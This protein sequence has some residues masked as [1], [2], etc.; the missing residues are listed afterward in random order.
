[1]YKLTKEN[2]TVI[3]I[4]DYALIPLPPNTPEGWNYMDWLA[5]GGIPEPYVE[6]PVTE[7][8]YANAIQTMLDT[9]AQEYRYDNIHTANGWATRFADALAL[10][11]WGAACWTY[12]EV[13]EADVL[14]GT[15]AMPTIAGLL[16]EMPVFVWPV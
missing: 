11:A 15:R 9:K 14:S 2:N 7:A 5:S 16:A 4:S 8:D 12:S 6:P 10:Q 13:V 1:M 3:R